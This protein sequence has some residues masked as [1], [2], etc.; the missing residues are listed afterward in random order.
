MRESRYGAAHGSTGGPAAARRPAM[1]GARRFPAR[2]DHLIYV[3]PD[4]E[5]GIDDLETRLG[6]RAAVGGSH[7]GRGTRN[8]LLALGEDVYLEVLAPDPAQPRPEKP[9]WLGVDR[10][11]PPRL[12]AWAVKTTAIPEAICAAEK[13][14]A[15]LGRVLAGSRLTS[16]GRR[17]SWTVS[18]PD[19]ILAGGIAPFLIDWGATP[20]PASGAPGGC[21]LLALRA[22]HPDTDAVRRTLA[23][24]G[25]DLEVSSGRAP[26]LIATIRCP[27]GDVE[28]S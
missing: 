1:D 19:V 7:P 26:R 16:E 28:L 12:S 24:I 27:R 20:H 6:V 15:M 11:G 2:L 22:E 4:L 23:A 10:V 25:L 3:T 18:D 21:A 14:G 8:A 9:R 17:L 13:S 5:A